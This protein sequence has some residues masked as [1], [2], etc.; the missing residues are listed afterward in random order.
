MD[1]VLDVVNV[2][3]I[4]PN[5]KKANAGINL[6]VYKGEIIGLIGPNGAGKTT[7]LRQILGLLKPTEAALPFWVKILSKIRQ[8]SSK[9]SVL[10]HNIRSIFLP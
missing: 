9:K 3:K 6:E 5:G 10:N 4:Y 1:K 7:L 2:T 8:S